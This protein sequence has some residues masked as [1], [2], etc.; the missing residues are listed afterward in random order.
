MTSETSHPNISLSF[1]TQETFSCVNSNDLKYSVKDEIQI[2][3]SLNNFFSNL[4]IKD[5][6]VT[7]QCSDRINDTH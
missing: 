1:P 7:K 5:C 6:V 4:Y 2:S 3:V